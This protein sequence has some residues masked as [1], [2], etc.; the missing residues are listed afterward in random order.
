MIN[1][2]PKQDWHTITYTDL[3]IAATSYRFLRLVADYNDDDKNKWREY[4]ISEQIENNEN[5]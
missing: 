4:E 1:P 2:V 5:F 3:Y